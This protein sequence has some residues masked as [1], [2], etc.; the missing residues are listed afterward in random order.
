MTR[1]ANSTTTEA[2]AGIPPLETPE[3]FPFPYAK[4]YGIQVQ[5]MKVVFKA[6]ENGKIAIVESPTGTGKSLTLLTS[7]LTWLKANEKRLQE[8]SLTEFEKA[9]KEVGPDDPPWVIE[10]SLQSHLQ[11]L[12]AKEFAHLERL[13]RAREKE[14]QRRRDAKLIGFGGRTKRQRILGPEHTS[15]ASATANV[16]HK[17]NPSTTTDDDDQFLPSDIGS[18]HGSRADQEDDNVSDEVKAL[19]QQFKAKPTE[20]EDTEEERPKVHILHIQNA[21]ATSAVDIRITQDHI[22]SHTRRIRAGH[23]EHKH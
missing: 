7:T 23:A 4:P 6:I 8:H 17:A 19:L 20:E 2:E 5:L 21:Y 16:G 14:I 10:H 18:S 9:L 15:S 22:C 3:I 12:K 13:A 1:L 11:D